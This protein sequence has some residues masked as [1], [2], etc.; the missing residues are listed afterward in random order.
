MTPC[1]FVFCNIQAIVADPVCTVC[2]PLISVVNLGSS[3]YGTITGTNHDVT[4]LLRL[5][6]DHGSVRK[7][8]QKRLPGF[9]HFLISDT[10]VRTANIRIWSV[11]VCLAK[12]LQNAQNIW[13]DFLGCLEV[14]IIFFLN[15][16][17]KYGFIFFWQQGRA[18]N[19][20]L[21]ETTLVN[22]LKTMSLK[23]A[24]W[25]YLKRFR[26]PN[27]FLKIMSLFH[28][29]TIWNDLKLQRFFYKKNNVSKACAL[30]EFETI[31]K[32]RERKWKQCL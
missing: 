6:V 1:Q 7:Y 14:I 4:F 25:W 22:I 16:I 13:F 17:I 28:S 27:I 30:K 15:N 19:L 20:T 26:T 31:W 32:C 2:T 9:K 12:W 23:H 5:S 11:R 3:W 18:C 21:F 24:F 8:G 29:D 10:E